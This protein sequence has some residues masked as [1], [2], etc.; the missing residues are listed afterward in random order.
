MNLNRLQ[1]LEKETQNLP[2][3]FLESCAG[4][5]EVENRTEQ[6]NRVL[7]SLVRPLH[8]EEQLNEALVEVSRVTYWGL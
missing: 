4:A 2:Q 5:P 1:K 6:L 8:R 7:D 3:V